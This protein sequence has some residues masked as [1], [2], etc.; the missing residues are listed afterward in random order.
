M[1]QDEE[2][3]PNCTDAHAAK[4]QS[5]EH[6]AHSVQGV[7]VEGTPSIGRG[8]VVST[9]GSISA[10]KGWLALQDGTFSEQRHA[11]HSSVQSMSAG[12][13]GVCCD[14]ASE[15]GDDIATTSQECQS[16]NREDAMSGP[17]TSNARE[18]LFAIATDDVL[19]KRVRIYSR[20]SIVES[21]RCAD[22]WY[23]PGHDHSASQCSEGTEGAGA[24]GVQAQETCANQH[25]TI[26]QEALMRQDE[27][28]SPNC[29]DA[30]AAKM[31]SH[32]HAAHSVQGVQVEGTPSIGRG[33]VV[34]TTGSI[35]AAKGW[36]ALQDGT[37]SEQRHA[38]HGSV[39]SMS[40]G[41]HGV[42]CDVASGVGD[43]IATT[44]QECQSDNREDPMS[45]PSTSNAR[46]G[47][48]AIAT[49]D[50][51]SKRVRIYSRPSIVEGQRCVDAQYLSCGDHSASKC[52]G[53]GTSAKQQ[54]GTGAEAAS[55]REEDYGEEGL[56]EGLAPSRFRQADKPIT[57][58][59]G[60]WD[61][62]YCK[63]ADKPTSEIPR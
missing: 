35:S 13:H 44:S 39:Q 36:Q 51:L 5:H 8:Q 27:E 47:V 61:G 20:P 30:H 12:S 22:V 34:S 46:E 18:G 63:T 42:C 31:Q 53:A 45:G 32:E 38:F 25:C 57:G 21:Q 29:T 9:T 60:P 55:T 24:S 48:F 41:S 40:A 10:A 3:S 16:D 59:L 2:D 6:A 7:Q 17:S 26:A 56:A 11:F 43:D 37:F 52:E 62:T 49:D 54:H 4:M 28:D 14:V 19:S 23:S 33:Q 15:V 58:D 50:V 1:R